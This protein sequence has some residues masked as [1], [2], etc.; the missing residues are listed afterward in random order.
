MYNRKIECTYYK[1]LGHK[2]SMRKNVLTMNE[3]NILEKY[4]RIGI[5]FI[6]ITLICMVVAIMKIT[7]KEV[8]IFSFCILVLGF[9]TI[10]FSVILLN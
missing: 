7:D 5:N 6:I 1:Y 9:F 3:N 10:L 2:P 8:L 4:K